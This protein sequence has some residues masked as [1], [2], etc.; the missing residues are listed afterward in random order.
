MEGWIVSSRLDFSLTESES[1]IAPEDI[2]GE[3]IASREG[4]AVVVGGGGA[5]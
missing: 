4:E 5:S 1:G 3:D 2:A